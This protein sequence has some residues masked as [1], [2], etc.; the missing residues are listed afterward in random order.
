M[1]FQYFSS[2]LKQQT[3]S[4]ILILCVLRKFLNCRSLFGQRAT[5]QPLKTLAP[6]G[7]RKSK[8]T[9]QITI[10]EKN[11]NYLFVTILCITPH[12]HTQ[13]HAHTH[14]NKITST[15][16]FSTNFR[17]NSPSKRI[18]KVS[19]KCYRYFISFSFRKYYALSRD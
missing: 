18:H 19:Q 8:D 5:P 14:Y 12:T 16:F 9:S 10:R 17:L 4:K 6:T 15:I 7:R 3:V 13:T 2:I 1:F 11:S